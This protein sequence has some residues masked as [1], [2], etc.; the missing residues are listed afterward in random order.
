[1]SPSLHTLL[2]HTLTNRFAHTGHFRLQVVGGGSINE[3]FRVSFG[4]RDLFCKYNSATNFP[5]LFTSEKQGLDFLAQQNA[6]KT[7]AVI[8]CLEDGGEQVLLLEWIKEGERTKT[9]WTTFGEQL[10]ALHRV[11]SDKHGFGDNNYM[12]SVPQAN[13]LHSNWIAFFYAERLAPMILRC[14]EKGLLQPVHLHQFETVRKKLGGIFEDESPSLL[15]GDLWS[16]N[17]LC[18]TLSEPVLIDPAVYFGHRSMDLAM[19]TLFGGF[20]Q[21]FYEAYHYHF[22]L[23]AN[24]EEQWAICNLYPLLIHLYLFGAGYLTQIERTLKQFA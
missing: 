14:T 3:T 1:M 7:P 5:H 10:A 16:G 15:H 20:R 2:R 18:N 22:P 8:A 11:T 19:T 4:E 17:F 21:P 9:F 6:I 12:G 24:Y 13:N 23:P